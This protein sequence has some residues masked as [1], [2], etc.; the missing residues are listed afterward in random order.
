MFSLVPPWVQVSGALTDVG[1]GAD[2]PVWG[3]DSAGNIYRCTG[4]RPS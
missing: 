4:D 2:G 3:V 1:A